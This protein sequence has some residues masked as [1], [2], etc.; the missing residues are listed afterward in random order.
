MSTQ[1][2]FGVYVEE[3]KNVQPIAVAHQNQPEA[4]PFDF[5]SHDGEDEPLEKMGAAYYETEEAHKPE[6]SKPAA[7]KPTQPKKKPVDIPTPAE[8][9]AAKLHTD[10]NQAV[11]EEDSEQTDM[12]NSLAR[13]YQTPEEL[14]AKVQKDSEAFA[15]K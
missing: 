7:A 4:V 1:T 9:D 3:P 10:I 13:S 15:E 6:P 11:Y 5:A 2:Q 12:I 14:E 8:Q